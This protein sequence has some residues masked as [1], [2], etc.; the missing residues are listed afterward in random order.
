MITPIL[1][2]LIL[3]S[4]INIQSSANPLEKL[5]TQ[6]NL[7]QATISNGVELIQGEDGKSITL[8]F[9]ASDKLMSVKIPLPNGP[10][11]WNNIGSLSFHSKSNSTIRYH[12]A[13][14]NSEKK[15]FAYSIHP[16]LNVPVRIAI[17]GDYLREKYMN[18]TQYKAFWIANW[19]NHINLDSVETI[20]ISMKPNQPVTLELN[21]FTIH[22]DE[23][24]DAILEDG[25]F[26]DQ[27]G[28]WIDLD[29]PGK[30]DSKEELQDTWAVE[31]QQLKEDFD[32]GY[33]RYGGWKAEKVKGTGFFRTMNI[34]DRW[35]LV[36]P[37][38]HLFFSI[39]MDCVRHRAPT[40][41]DD[42]EEIFK[43]VPPKR[44]QEADFYQANANLRY[45]NEGNIASFMYNQ[46]QILRN[47]AFTE[48]WKN[49]QNRRLR[50][51]GFNT[52]GNWSNRSLWWAP[53]LPFV[54][55]L[56]FN[57]TGKNWQ[58]FPDVY[59]D[60]FVQQ[61]EVEA[62][63]QCTRFR[64]EPLL[65]GYFT[66][67]EERWPHRHFID[68]ILNDPEPSATQTHVIEYFKKNR[69]TPETREQLTEDLAR[70]YFQTVCDA[71]RKADPNHLILGIRWA[72]GRAPDPVIKAND[73]FD[74][75]SL[76]FYKFQPNPDQIKRLHELTGLPIVI[77]EFH[78]G[79]AGRGYAP[80]LV[81]VK[82]QYERGVAYQYYV[83][84]AAS[85]PMI[86]G[87]HYFQYLDQPVTGRFDGE[88]YLFGFVNQQ[89]IPY[90]EMIKHARETHQQIYPIHLGNMRPTDVRAK[91]R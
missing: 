38:G 46:N 32:F 52:V 90:Q 18:N 68:L 77:G 5:L 11:D 73:V 35:W 62:M 84:Q 1:S 70:K 82:D 59:S 33:S 63:Q 57:R 78:F 91:I 72:G 14:H 26:V 64:D 79:S 41:V 51:W 8:K 34:D 7:R 75:F 9:P 83:E 40:K 45:G 28:Q 16:Y 27:F 88:N 53:D 76:N 12:V 48:N 39:G 89:D 47:W 24:E 2:F 17:N 21:N 36:D 30:I 69:D 25:P 55:N 66:G 85:M 44:G 22:D 37:D 20:E 80:S 15:R 58:K 86:I 23:I 31:N 4:S 49:T 87:T 50:K 43:V 71:I 65:I 6:S 10:Q 67:N 3:C 61:T 29:W 60:Q 42:R 54:A 74:V 56:S 81:Q 19:G 13:I